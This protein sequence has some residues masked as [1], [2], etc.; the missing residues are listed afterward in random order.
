MEQ[1]KNP[2]GDAC[3]FDLPDQEMDV[4][5]IILHKLELEKLDKAL[6][7]IPEKERQFIMDCFEAEWGAG[8]EIAEKYGMTIGAV[9]QRKRRI[10]KKIRKMYFSEC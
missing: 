4:E 5:Q 6:S 8:K 7:L 3:Y 1:L 10:I 2:E 9:K